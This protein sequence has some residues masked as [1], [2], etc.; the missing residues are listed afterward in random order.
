MRLFIKGND[1]PAG[2][3]G[4]ELSFEAE[5]MEGRPIRIMWEHVQFIE[6]VDQKKYEEIRA[7]KSEVAIPSGLFNKLGGGRPQ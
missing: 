6:K 2:P 4:V 1:Y 5:T 7:K 3:V